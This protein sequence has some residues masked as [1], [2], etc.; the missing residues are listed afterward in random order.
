MIDIAAYRGSATAAYLI[1]TVTDAE[2]VTEEVLKAGA[3]GSC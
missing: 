2:Q 3:R 1:L